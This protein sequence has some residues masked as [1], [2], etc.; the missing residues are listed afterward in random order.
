MDR[1]YIDIAQYKRL[2]DE[3]VCYVNKMKKNL[4]YERQYSEYFSAAHNKCDSRM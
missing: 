3:G 1:G 4:K 2:T